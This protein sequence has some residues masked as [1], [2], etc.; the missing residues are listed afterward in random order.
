[1]FGNFNSQ[2]KQ[3]AAN[4]FANPFA[5]QQQPA[6]NPFA[7]SQPKQQA[8]NSFANPFATTQPK[9]QAANP[10]ANPFAKQQQPAANG[11]AT[12][13]PKQQAANPFA[14]PF[15]K[16]QPQKVNPFAASSQSNANTSSLEKDEQKPAPEE[17]ATVVEN[18]NTLDDIKER[19]YPADYVPRRE[20]MASLRSFYGD[21]QESYKI[22]DECAKV[23]NDR[24]EDFTEEQRTMP[25]EYARAVICYTAEL[26]SKQVDSPY[27]LLNKALRE[28]NFKEL[29]KFRDLFYILLRSFRSLKL[30]KYEKLYR[31]IHD[32][33]PSIYS[34]GDTVTWSSFSSTSK[35]KS[36]AARFAGDGVLLEILNANGYSLG[37]FS[38]YPKEE[39]ILLDLDTTFV[40]REIKKPEKI[41]TSD[42]DIVCPTKVV[43][44]CV[45]TTAP[46]KDFMDEVAKREPKGSLKINEHNGTYAVFL[47][48]EEGD[49][50]LPMVDG[51]GNECFRNMRTGKIDWS[52]RNM[53]LPEGWVEEVDENGITY[54]INRV[55]RLKTYDRPV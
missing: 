20:L 43:L 55:M 36:V 48:D 40:V 13:Q 1:M 16:Q 9:Q 42:L 2:P 41:T 23:L 51:T 28:K 8:A 10:F 11:F 15:A 54:Y 49:E 47:E 37:E 35:N 27:S 7:T 21:K 5:K 6:A 44:E 52:A 30:D 19:L 25:I 34:V 45:N 17:E 33:S 4:P 31:G 38:A 3:Q 39:E 14:N 26:D 12:S 46:L 50:W 53:P 18:Y 22:F 24:L 32:I 29:L